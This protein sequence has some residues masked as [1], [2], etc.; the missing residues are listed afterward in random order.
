MVIDEKPY[1][2]DRVFRL[3]VTIGVIFGLIYLARYLSDVLIPFAVAYLLAYLINPLVQLIQRKIPNRPLAVVIALVLVAVVIVIAGWVLVHYISIEVAEAH[4]LL[5]KLYGDTPI[6]ERLGKVLPEQL[7]EEIRQFLAQQDMQQLL[8]KGDT[9]GIGATIGR[10]VLAHLWAVLAGTLSMLMGLVG[11]F[12]IVLYLFFLLIDYRIVASKG[13]ELIPPKYRKTVMGFLSDFNEAMSRHF[14]AQALMA[15]IVGV[16]FAIG[17]SIVGLPM[18]VLF[19]LF[20]GLLNMIP[21]LQLV[22]ILPAALLA[23]L[24]WAE[25]G[26]NLLVALAMTGAVFAVVQLLQDTLL[27]PRIMGKS[28]GLRPAM[29]LLSVSIWGKL[30]GFLGLLLALPLT[31][32]A[33]AYYYRLLGGAGTEKR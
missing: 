33:L 24:M 1:N 5:K 16:L 18:A 13:S 27:T 2:F 26:G 29:I 25:K 8:Q 9:W 19:G 30:L 6:T 23:I 12:V 10:N 7:W 21:Y 31:C 15:T 28:S 4:E 22:A 32:L 14:R 3:M 11:L 20:V 17:F